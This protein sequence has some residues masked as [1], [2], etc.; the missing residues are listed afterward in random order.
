MEY[1]DITLMMYADGEL[2]HDASLQLK[3]D[4]LKDRELQERLKVF[5]KTR[6]ALLELT[7]REDIPNHI[8]RLID[9]H[10]RPKK[11][12]KRKGNIV[13]LFWGHPNLALAASVALGV[14]IGAKGM[15]SM[16]SGADLP[17]LDFSTKSYQ[18]VK[19]KQPVAL[20]QSEVM[21]SGGSNILQTG[22]LSL[23]T[24]LDTE[25]EKE[26]MS[27]TL[28][29]LDHTI[30]IVSDFTSAE[31]RKCKLAQLQ[32]IYLIACVDEK[33]SWTVRRSK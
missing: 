4:L 14:V 8:V 24:S 28:D 32:D 33:G 6:E 15:Q 25:P 5:T 18:S 29:G 27:F 11:R 21:S 19:S 20:D 16:M 3:K 10:D 30:R 12:S 7:D 23:I 13:Q 22:I 9:K 1:D 17:E 26:T 2:D 31:G